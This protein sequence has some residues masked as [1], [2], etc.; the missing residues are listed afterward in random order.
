MREIRRSI[1]RL[2]HRCR[3]S[4]PLRRSLQRAIVA[5][6]C[7]WL[8]LVPPGLSY[9]WLIDP[10]VHTQID[11]ERFGQTPDGRT[12]PDHPERPPH[13]H[14][15]SAAMVVSA[16]LLVAVFGVVV[17]RDVL[18]VAQRPWLHDRRFEA[19]LIGESVALRPPKPPPRA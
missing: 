16:I 11:A 13:E 7:A 3:A 6:V 9:Y 19:G 2:L 1:R 10:E 18:V 17:Y 12:L 15:A 5:V 14:P 4:P 8:V